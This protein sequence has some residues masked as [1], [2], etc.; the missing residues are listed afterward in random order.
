MFGTFTPDGR[1]FLTV[2]A[3]RSQNGLS[4]PAGSGQISVVRVSENIDSPDESPTSHR[5]VSNAPTGVGPVGAAISPDGS[6]VACGNTQASAG[7][8]AGGGS[9]SLYKLGKDGSLTPCGEF[10][11][12]AVPAGV[13]FDTHGRFVLVSQYRSLDPE[14]ADGE[15]SFWKIAGSGSPVLEQQD[16]FLGIGGGPHG[17]LIV[18]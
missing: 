8:G 9:V 7:G 1:F 6:L 14:A 10:P 16:F 17:V 4:Q 18:R 13:T 15:V 5:V 12:G 3:N 11:V 2:D